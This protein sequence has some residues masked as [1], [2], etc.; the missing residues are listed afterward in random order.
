MVTAGERGKGDI[1]GEG[2]VTAELELGVV[3]DCGLS[4]WTI[5]GRVWLGLRSEV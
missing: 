2:G 3:G 5:D 4:H 1:L